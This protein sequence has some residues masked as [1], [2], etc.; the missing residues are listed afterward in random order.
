MCVNA[1]E[2][3]MAAVLQNQSPRRIGRFEVVREL[4]RGAQG[5]VYLANDTRLARP[6]AL[7]TLHG[8]E[9]GLLDEARIVA[10]GVGEDRSQ[11]LLT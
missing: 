4:G 5:A 10:R 1:P 3:R 2:S 8:L 7:K 11:E 6:V 9:L